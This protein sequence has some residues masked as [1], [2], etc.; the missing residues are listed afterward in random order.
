MA[1]IYQDS[2]YGP[3]A[4]TKHNDIVMNNSQPC[5]G[6]S[7]RIKQLEEWLTTLEEIIPEHTAHRSSLEGI[8]CSLKAAHNKHQQQHDEIVTEAPSAEDL[9]EYLTAY[10]SALAPAKEAFNG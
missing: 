10:A 8:Y 4:F 3:S 2:S 6:W 9:M 7:F 5:V 1:T